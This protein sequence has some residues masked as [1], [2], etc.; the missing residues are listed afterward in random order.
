MAYENSY[1]FV[2][3]M[4]SDDIHNI[5]SFSELW[6]VHRYLSNHGYPIRK[7]TRIC[8]NVRG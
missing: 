4:K 1:A 2:E 8:K 7:I 5:A 6:S 3:Y